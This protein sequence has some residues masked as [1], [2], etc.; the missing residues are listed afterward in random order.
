MGLNPSNFE[1]SWSDAQ[2]ANTHLKKENI[3][4]LQKFGLEGTLRHIYTEP[5]CRISPLIILSCKINKNE[6]DTNISLSNFRP[7]NYHDVSPDVAWEQNYVNT[8]SW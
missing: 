4:F 6:S 1:E 2:W 7:G 5:H 3:F 8:I